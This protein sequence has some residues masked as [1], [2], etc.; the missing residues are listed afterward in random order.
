MSPP[1]SWTRYGVRVE[2]PSIRHHSICIREALLPNHDRTR[3]QVAAEIAN[4]RRAPT[5][6]WARYLS[7]PPFTV[8][9]R[10]LI[11]R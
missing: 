8:S 4:D 6:E 1:K 10:T 5:H 7:Y 9:P 2:L 11:R 3:P